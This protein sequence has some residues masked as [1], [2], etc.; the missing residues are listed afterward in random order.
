MSFLEFDPMNRLI[1]MMVVSN[2]YD[3]LVVYDR[4]RMDRFRPLLV[5]EVPSLENGRI[6]ADGL[7]YRFTIRNDSTLTPEDVEYSF[8][9]V[10]VYS[11]GMAI[12]SK[13]V[14]RS[15]RR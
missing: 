14:N 10:M 3:T 12:K 13:S 4:E 15:W 5:T 8:E 9:R 7:T 2:C 6:S 1:S 11:M